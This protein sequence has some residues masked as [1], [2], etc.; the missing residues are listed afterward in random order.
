M[1]LRAFLLVLILTAWAATVALGQVP[2]DVAT[3]VAASTTQVDADARIESAVAAAVR[4]P[5]LWR[6]PPHRAATVWG[7]KTCL[8]CQV[9]KPDIATLQ[10]E[11]W[12]I[13]Y[14]ETEANAAAAQT[15]SVEQVPLLVIHD[16]AERGRKEV[17]RHIGFAD[18]GR[19]RATLRAQRVH[20][21][22]T[23]VP[24]PGAAPVPA[25]TPPGPPG[26]AGP[27]FFQSGCAGG[28]CGTWAR[29][30]WRSR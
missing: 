8:P 27:A 25:A 18:I 15:W 22:P 16:H 5:R 29:G 2:P 7:S 30:N 13:E 24:Q 28:S 20:Q 21:E 4:P 17:G 19:L 23:T 1:R 14:Q 12:E 6:N 11:G 26:T 3:A 10:K 9:M